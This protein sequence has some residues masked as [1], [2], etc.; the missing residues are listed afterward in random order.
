MINH[1][2]SWNLDITLHPEAVQTWEGGLKWD[3]R[4]LLLAHNVSQWSKDPST[5]V[6]CV[7]VQPE[8]NRVLSLGYNGF[9]RGVHDT[10]ERLNDRDLKYKMILHAERNA[11]L[12][13]ERSVQGATLYTWPF[14]PCRSC[15]AMIIQAGIKRVVTVPGMT[16]AQRERWAEDLAGA[17]EMFAEA[18]VKLCVQDLAHEQNIPAG[19]YAQAWK[20]KSFVNLR[21]DTMA[22]CENLHDLDGALAATVFKMNDQW[23]VLNRTPRETKNNA[24]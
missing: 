18:G 4:F 8:T 23:W 7:I 1:S 17:S 15:A 12:S 11:L 24:T 3:R 6:G 22:P 20:S 9:P 19:E 21:T 14:A 10:P 2:M 5:Q 16:E 13:A